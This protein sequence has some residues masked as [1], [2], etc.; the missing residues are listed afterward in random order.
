MSEP[1]DD[2]LARQKEFVDSF[3]R[4]GAELASELIDANEKL[5]FRVVELEAELAAARQKLT[6]FNAAEAAARRYEARFAEIEHENHNLASLYVAAYQLHSTLDVSAVL[7]TIV[8]ILVNFVGAR[9]FAIYVV[10]G[11]RLVPIATQGLAEGSV[12]R[13]ALGDPG[14]GQV[15]ASG[16][17]EYQQAPGVVAAVPMRL[18]DSTVGAIAV[19]ELLTHKPALDEV[20]YELFN[21]LAA[22]AATA[23]EAARLAALARAGG[24]AQS[25]GFAALASLPPV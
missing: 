17:A 10:D 5:R 1:S 18:G 20:D 4:K 19:F 23:L 14:L 11:A 16:T 6:G 7:G 15:A 2:L 25:P 3:F 12:P 9:T 13:P 8:E 22:H 24:A 21:L